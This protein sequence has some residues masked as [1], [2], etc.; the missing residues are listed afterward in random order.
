MELAG[1]KFTRF[2]NPP[3]RSYG[4]AGEHEHEYKKEN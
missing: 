4:A 2:D 1:A 3:S